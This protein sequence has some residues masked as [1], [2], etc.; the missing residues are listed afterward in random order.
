MYKFCALSGNN[1]Y[2]IKNYLLQRE[3]WI[4]IGEDLEKALEQADFI[5]KP[6]NLPRRVCLIF[7][8]MFLCYRYYMY[9]IKYF[10]RYTAD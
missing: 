9:C 2:L 4:D 8:L 6:T 7:N 5:W 3:V 1:S 10:F